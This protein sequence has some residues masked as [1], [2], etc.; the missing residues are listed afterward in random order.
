MTHITYYKAY[1]SNI[2]MIYLAQ[3]S[4]NF[5][6]SNHGMLPLQ[7]HTDMPDS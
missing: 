2:A 6:P 7:T 1:Y 4:H 3:F 5:I